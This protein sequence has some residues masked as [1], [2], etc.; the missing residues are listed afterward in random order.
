MRDIAKYISDAKIK[1]V[2]MQ[3]CDCP[4]CNEIDPNREKPLKHTATLTNGE[5]EV[6]FKLFTR[7]I[8]F[9]VDSYKQDTAY[10]LVEYAE[11]W[12]KRFGTRLPKNE[13]VLMFHYLNDQ[14]YM[15]QHDDYSFHAGKNMLED[16]K[17]M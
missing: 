14:N 8:R 2:L 7:I 13:F 9:L 11:I 12:R 10:N 4:K 3:G 15:C 1:E 6:P 16:L 5:T 17:C